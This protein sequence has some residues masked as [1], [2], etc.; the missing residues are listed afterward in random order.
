MEVTM[1]LTTALMLYYCATL[2]K[3][4]LTLENME[5]GAR[6]IRMYN[7]LLMYFKL[8]SRTKYSY[9]TLHLLAQIKKFISTLPFP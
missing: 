6:I 1:C 3:T 2:L 4:S 9:Q 7:Y 5:M 8:D